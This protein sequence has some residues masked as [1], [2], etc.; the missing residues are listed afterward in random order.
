MKPNC[1]AVA[2]PSPPHFRGRKHPR[3][4][5]LVPSRQ[6][7]LSKKVNPP[8]GRGE[9]AEK[10]RSRWSTRRAQFRRERERARGGSVD[11]DAAPPPLQFF[12]GEKR[13]QEKKTYHAHERRDER[14]HEEGELHFSKRQGG[15]EEERARVETTR[16]GVVFFLFCFC[17]ERASEA[18]VVVGGFSSDALLRFS[19]FF[20]FRFSRPRSRRS[21]LF[22]LPLL[23]L[24]SSLAFLSR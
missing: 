20:S 2:S 12:E 5:S 3:P 19:L 6:G 16:E 15:R 4:S 11:G 13:G 8:Q 18:S 10:W 14:E 23:L 24:A 1:R 17:V 22:L 9:R 21:L 7:G